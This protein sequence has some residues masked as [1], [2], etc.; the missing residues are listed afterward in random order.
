VGLDELQQAHAAAQEHTARKHTDQIAEL[1]RQV[2][3]AEA[4]AERISDL[5]EQLRDRYRDWEQARTRIR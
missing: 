4:Q 3:C 1:Q 5:E 2:G